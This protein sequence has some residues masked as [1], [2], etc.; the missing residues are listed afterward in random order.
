MAEKKPQPG[1]GLLAERAREEEAPEG[2]MPPKGKPDMEAPPAE[3]APDE[4]ASNVTPEEQAAYD[5]FVDNCYSLIYDKK[6]IGNVL[7]SLDATDDPKMNL[8]NTTVM[9][10]KRV[11]DSARQAG[12]QVS[13]DVLM[14]GGAEVLEDLADLAAK[15]GL[16]SYT[17]DEI[18]GA[19]Y[20]AADLYRGMAEA[21]GTLDIEGSKRDMAMAIQADQAGQM[22]AIIP[23]A[24][25]R[26]G[27]KKEPAEPE[28]EPPV[29][30]EEAA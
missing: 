27:A 3:G 7:K 28:D 1:N 29:E 12:Q 16:H 6:T 11:A 22:D 15:M 19:V 14:H 8:A 4:E 2:K 24:S 23:G 30:D 18:E 17:P 10:V 5:R 21:D 26:F 25:A 20:I 13:V 9:I